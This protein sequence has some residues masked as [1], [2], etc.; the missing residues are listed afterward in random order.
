MPW[1][2][3]ADRAI[4][5][6]LHIDCGMS[7]GGWTP[8][9]LGSALLAWYKADADT[10]LHGVSPALNGETVDTWNDSSGNSRHLISNGAP[11]T[12]IV[13]NT[14]AFNGHKAVV[15]TEGSGQVLNCTSFPMGTGNAGSAWMAAQISTAGGVRRAVVYAGP[16]HVGTDT[17]SFMFFITGGASTNLRNYQQGF[18]ADSTISNSTN[19]RLASI[20]GSGASNIYVDN[21]IGTAGAPS[22]NFATNGTLT[23]GGE[24]TGASDCSM[25]VAEMFITNT[26]ETANLANAH[27]YLARWL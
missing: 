23:I 26:D 16:G 10:V 13:Y 15:F 12:A 24:N 2:D 19:Y 27:T 14:T 18:Q 7:A 3:E 11:T 6:S 25:T 1:D 9:S 22:F 4:E 5:Y 8:T 17:D 21:V 20:V